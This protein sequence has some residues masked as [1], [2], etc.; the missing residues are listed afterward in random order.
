[1][2]GRWPQQAQNK[3]AGS[4]T[5]CR[6]LY[7]FRDFNWSVPA[8]LLSPSGFHTDG[9][10]LTI[11][12]RKPYPN[13]GVIQ[14]VHDIGYGNY[15]A[16]SLKVT[17]RYSVSIWSSTGSRL[18]I[19]GRLAISGGPEADAE[20]RRG[21]G[22]DD[23]HAEFNVE[24]MIQSLIPGN[25]TLSGVRSRQIEVLADA[26]R[27]LASSLCD[28]RFEAT[29]F[30]ANEAIVFKRPGYQLTFDNADDLGAFIQKYIPAAKL[31]IREK[32]LPIPRS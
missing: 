9:T 10:P 27:N 28:T 16:P 8:G 4:S 14:L 25:F 32:L 11:N 17:K 15:N 2:I 23:L 31:A 1:M 12:K 22:V 24:W 5:L 19:R 13:F 7:D 20:R 26:C 29:I 3:Q 6:N 30:H 21:S 18:T